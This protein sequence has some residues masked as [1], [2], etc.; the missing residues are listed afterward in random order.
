[1]REFTNKEK[2]LM[3]NTP[4]TRECFDMTDFRDF[5]SISERTHILI[6]NSYAFEVVIDACEA[7]R[8]MYK[9][10]YKVNLDTGEKEP[11]EYY[12]TELIRLLPNSYKVVKL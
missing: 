11:M 9:T 5:E 12:F 8:K 10:M 4:I 3:V 2:E 1:M 6:H 7:L